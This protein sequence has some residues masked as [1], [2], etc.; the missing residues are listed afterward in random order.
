M[1][2]SRVR[3][4]IV[5]GDIVALSHYKWASLY[6]LKVQAVRLFTQSEY[7]HVG[8]AIVFGGRVW[9]AESVT[10][11]VRL[12]PLS[13]FVKDGFYLIK[14]ETPM[15]EAEQEFLLSKVGVAPYSQWQAIKAYFHQLKIGEDDIYECAEYVI[16]ARKMS[17]MDLGNVA[18]PSAVVREAGKLGCTI[19]YID[20]E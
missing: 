11:F 6:D 19:Q 12:V 3:D 9:I 2:Y 10:P 20:R 13:N 14:T 5:S 15:T 8:V 16:C 1:Q 4:K 18:T 17:G 7:S